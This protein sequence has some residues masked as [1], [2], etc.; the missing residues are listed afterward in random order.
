MRNVPTAA[1][2]YENPR[3]SLHDGLPRLCPVMKREPPNTVFPLLYAL[4]KHYQGPH[5]GDR[6]IHGVP[7]KLVFYITVIRHSPRLG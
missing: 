2:T 7:A 1:I 4:G 3:P 5:R 6:P